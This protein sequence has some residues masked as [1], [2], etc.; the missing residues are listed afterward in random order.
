MAST[1]DRA[2][3]TLP[4]VE[5][6]TISRPCADEFQKIDAKEVRWRDPAGQEFP[7]TATHSFLKT[8]D[9]HENK[10]TSS[11]HPVCLSLYG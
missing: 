4:G 7:M 10:V 3:A 6:F 2:G 11:A 9:R 1:S 5:Q 8:K